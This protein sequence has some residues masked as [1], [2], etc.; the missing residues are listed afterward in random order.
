M[1]PGSLL[2]PVTEPRLQFY[3][4]LG[5][6]Y[7]TITPILFPFIIVFF[8]FDYMFFRH[9]WVHINKGLFALGNLIN[10]LGDEKKRKEVTMDL[11]GGP[12]KIFHKISQIQIRIFVA[13]FMSIATGVSLSINNLDP[14]RISFLKQDATI[15]MKN[16]ASRNELWDIVIMDPPK[17][18]PRRKWVFDDLFVFRS[19]DSEEWAVLGCSPGDYGVIEEETTKELEH[20][21]FQDSIDKELCELNKQLEHK[22]SDVPFF[23]VGVIGLI[24]CYHKTFFNLRWYIV[25]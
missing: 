5:L 4:L 16:V 1:D 24:L 21:L 8:A 22:E 10:A 20:T 15:F 13:N 11:V 7:S 19:Y 25:E 17:L 9:Q 14:G 2:W 23:I 6:V 18:A 12:Q 3:F